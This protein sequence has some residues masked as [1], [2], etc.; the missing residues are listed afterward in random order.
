MIQYL[1]SCLRKQKCI[2]ISESLLKLWYGFQ[3]VVQNYLTIQRHAER[4]SIGMSNGRWERT[5]NSITGW[6][7]GHPSEKYESQLGWLFPIYRK[8]KH[9]NQTTNQIIC[10][11]LSPSRPVFAGDYST[12][13]CTTSLPRCIIR[14][15]QPGAY[16]SVL[17]AIE[18]RFPS[19]DGY[20]WYT[21]ARYM[22]KPI[23]ETPLKDMVVSQNGDPQ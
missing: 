15:E 21:A 6:W 1:R 16:P 20:I 17:G 14:R 2:M 5:C 8:I 4:K 13:G 18:V 12:A 10:W 7:L 23:Q 22:P 9:G 19:L 3:K 11:V